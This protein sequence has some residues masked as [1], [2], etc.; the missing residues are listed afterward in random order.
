MAA[1]RRHPGFSGSEIS[2]GSTEEAPE[3]AEG[4]RVKWMFPRVSCV[5]ISIGFSV[6]KSELVSIHTS[7]RGVDPRLETQIMEMKVVG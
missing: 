5:S 4:E 3:R 6:G 1:A 7:Q 2:V